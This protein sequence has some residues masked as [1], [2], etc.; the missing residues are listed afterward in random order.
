MTFSYGRALQASAL[1]AWGGKSENIQ[2]AK[3]AF[4][5]RAEANSLAQQGKYTGGAGSGAA[6]QNLYVANHSY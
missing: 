1:A 2:A 6:A 5:K 3:E 4:L